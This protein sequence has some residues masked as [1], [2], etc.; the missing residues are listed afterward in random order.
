MTPE[1][2]AQR[3]EMKFLR[4]SDAIARIEEKL[5]NPEI[6]N[7]AGLE[8]NLERLRIDRD[9]LSKGH[10]LSQLRLRKVGLQVFPAPAHIGAH[11]AKPKAK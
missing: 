2:E 3:V 11:G 9:I 4:V 7:R 1:E 5:R 8:H 6:P 10:E